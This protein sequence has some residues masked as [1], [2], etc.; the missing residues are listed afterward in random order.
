MH[1]KLGN[2]VYVWL[3]LLLVAQ[4][5]MTTMGTI[6]VK[7]EENQTQKLASLDSIKAKNDK[8]ELKVTIKN[9]E[10]ASKVK[11]H[12]KTNVSLKKASWKDSKNKASIQLDKENKTLIVSIPKDADFK[13]TIEL[14]LGESVTKSEKIQFIYEEQSLAAVI[15]ATTTKT[16]TKTATK[17]STKEKTENSKKSNDKLDASKIKSNKQSIQQ[18]KKAANEGTDIRSYF[19]NENATIITAAHTVYL[20]SDG[21]VLQ[22]PIPADA[23][24]R[25]YYNWE[26]PENIR[27]QMKAG[28]YFNF[29]LPDELKPLKEMEGDLKNT[30]GE[31]YAHYT[32]DTDGNVQFVFNENVTTESNISGDFN[33]D[34]EFN[35]ATIP[36][37][38]D[39]TIHFPEADNL[40]PIDVI[41]K[42]ATDKEI[43]KK[44]AFDRSPNP[45]S[46]KWT[47]DFNQAMNALTNP[48]ITENWPDGTTYQSAKIYK[49]VMNLDG[50]VKEVGEQLDPSEYTIDNDGNIKLKGKTNDAYRVVYD[51]KIDESVIP[52]D[53]GNLSFSNTATLSDDTQP[54][55]IDAKASLTTKYGKMIEKEKTGYD[56]DTQTFSWAIHYNY[57]EKT[58]PENQAVITDTLSDNMDLVDGSVEIHA[59]S[60]DANG[61]EVK[62]DTLVEGSDYTLTPTA[63]GK[64][65]I[66]FLHA[67]NSAIKID[68]K[69]KVSDIVTDTT[70]VTNK[71][72]TDTGENSEDGG[73]ANQ[74]NI[75]KQ[76]GSVD[77]AKELS[78][79]T[80]DVNK[81]GYEMNDLVIKDSYSP[82]PGLTMNTVNGNYDFTIQ[83][84]TANKT[85]VEGTDYDLKLVKSDSGDETGFQVTYKGDYANT[86]HAFKVTY[87]TKFDITLLD[88]NDPNLDKF[89]NTAGIDWSDGSNN[90]HHSDD[91][92]DFKPDYAYSLNALKG[93]EYNAQ[94]KQITWTMAVNLSGNELKDAFLQDK[95]LDNQNYVGDSLK[96]YKGHT[97]ADGTVT[98]ESD[99]AINDQMKAVIAPSASNDQTLKV[100][101]P[102]G[103]SQ[104]YVIE[105]K[106]SLAGQIIENSNAYD[107]VAT[108][109]NKDQSRDV[110]G[111]VS[112]KNGGSFI[113]KEGEQN[114]DNPDY[115]DWHAVI[116]PSLSTLDNVV[117]TDT[118][119]E[120]QSIDKDS[121]KLYET[122]I[123]E[124]GT[125]TPNKEKPLTL[126][127]DY[128]VELT[129]DNETGEQ[130]L[131]V[132]MA[133]KI[134][135]AYYMEYQSY[136]TSST[137]GKEDTVSNAI[138]VT[139]D[140]TKTIDGDDSKDVVV[141][142]DHSGG[143][144]NGKKGSL[145]IQK[146][147]ADTTQP[148]TGATFQIWDTS[149]TQ[150]LRE[151]KVDENGQIKFGGLPQGEYLLVESKAP[152]GYVIADDLVS[153]R[154]IT[155]N[156]QT[157]A[158]TAK[159]VV[160][161]QINELVVTKA[162]SSG[163]RLAGAE[164][165]LERLNTLLGDK[166]EKVPLKTDTTNA[167]GKLS[168]E[169][170]QAGMYRLTEIK[171]PAGYLL[172][173]SKQYFVVS[174]NGKLSHNKTISLF[175]V[176]YQGTAQLIKKMPMGKN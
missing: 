168:V 69:T 166:W 141:E 104:T 134:D 118:P 17:A 122:T 90:K 158:E 36:G 120:N 163:Q 20:D 107:N 105:F 43:D 35:K 88:P 142:V 76:L 2:F 135:T 37:P 89:I 57:G 116:N 10:E 111:E 55:G 32:I 3:V 99:D 131:T 34:T 51:T 172:N 12:Y 149:K 60:F 54:E 143:N 101:F 38:G 145:T 18:A 109:S 96:I 138:H 152:S 92:A 24:V 176:D 26:I 78:T 44:G 128:T 139:G 98:K 167:K 127:K 7:G 53:G 73:T 70:A 164:F 136:I 93:G 41:I 174:S 106:T 173:T 80:L 33:F 4:A 27:S 19:S 160:P 85:L 170:L 140:G 119:S 146:T 22:E 123:A 29:Q 31:V 11:I 30:D 1:K 8:V 40:P 112:V 130:K 97:E 16:E 23:T 94:T 156:D 165:E 58:I 126:N 74:E 68:Y 153:G 162:N 52:K 110:T 49:L 39:Q 169:G 66:N 157:S 59:I 56:A 25:V 151:S 102:D 144:A 71:V 113:Q 6:S 79:W 161:N 108:Y 124:D 67:I 61:N 9:E 125:V 46:I 15:Q 147:K 47:V 155:I 65:K 21:N 42:P 82:S 13:D 62:G 150:L 132:K 175:K 103:G 154:K 64:F 117:I 72:E 86:D 148:L 75:I 45:T 50:T 87:Q 63:D 91:E 48:K 14:S 84:V 77:Y 159:Y 115:V 121:I 5:F 95:V 114:K 28:D 133:N 137:E 100:L 129:T 171:A 81:N 83:D